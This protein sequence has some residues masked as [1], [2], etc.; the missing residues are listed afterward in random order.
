M[1][2]AELGILCTALKDVIDNIGS[3]I[4]RG[5]MLRDSTVVVADELGRFE[6]LL[7][8]KPETVRKHLPGAI[9]EIGIFDAT[10]QT[11]IAER[12]RHAAILLRCSSLFSSCQHRTAKKRMVSG[13]KK[14]H[15]R[16]AE[17]HWKK[18]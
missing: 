3:Q 13:E 15:N 10:V 16:S 4:K 9:I 7:P 17:F 18:L 12:G 11:A 2:T 8:R 14:W 6:N 1:S 5:G